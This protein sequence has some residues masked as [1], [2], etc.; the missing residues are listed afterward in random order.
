MI[1][2]RDDIK[3]NSE[4]VKA[5]VEWKKFTHLKKIQAF[6]DFVNFYR[7]FIKDFFKVTKSLI[8]LIRKDHLFSWF[9]D[10]QT[11]FNELKKRVTEASILS[12]FSFELKT[13]LKSDS[14]NYVSIEILFQKEDDDFIKSITYFSKTLFSAECNY[15]IYDKKLLTIIR[16]F[17]Q[18]RVELQSMK[19][20][21]NVLI[22]HKSLK[23][24]MITK[25]L[26]KR[27][28][29]W[30]KFL[31]KFDFKI[32]YQSEKKNDKANS[33]IKRSRNRSI[34]ESDDR[35]KHMHQT[36]LSTKK[37]DSRIVQQINDIE[38]NSN[39]VGSL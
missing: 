38:E 10:C 7:R 9:K 28:T 12:Y 27:Q 34:N 23:Y 1:M 29:R 5:I 33:L 21:I 16:C 17:E 30:A 35:N 31:A 22:D 4:K 11:T 37:V 20:F 6:F 25:K 26:N 14:S 8:K 3:I 39:S 18:W 32:A 36:I 15:E 13:F 19:T 2:R 24:F